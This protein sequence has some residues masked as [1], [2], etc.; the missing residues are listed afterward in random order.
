MGAD[1][2]KNVC[3]YNKTRDRHTHTTCNWHEWQKKIGVHWRTNK[4]LKELN[5][6]KTGRLH[7]FL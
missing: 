6:G 5:G 7:T 1:Y 3:V 2:V 4:T